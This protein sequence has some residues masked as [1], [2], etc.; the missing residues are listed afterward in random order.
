M[1]RISLW[2]IYRF[3]YALAFRSFDVQ[4]IRGVVRL[5]LEPCTYWRNIEVPAVLTRLGVKPGEKVLDL[6]SPKLASLLLSSRVGAEVWATDL[7]AYFTEEYAH[8]LKKLRDAGQ[9]PGYHIELQD[10][11]KLQYP[12]EFFDKVYSISVLEHIEGDGDSAAMREIARVLKPGGL[13]CLTVPATR[14]YSEETTLRHLYYKKHATG[15]PV[16]YQRQYDEAALRNRLVNP[17]G[18]RLSSVALYGERWVPYE[19][20][21]SKLPRFIKLPVSALGPLFS[22]LFLYEIDEGWEGEPKAAL[23]VLE[24]R[25]ASQECG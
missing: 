25:S 16:F 11:R 4:H 6:G 22:L 8:Y 23:V 17:S 13:C 14:T 5:L 9:N 7:F 19:R 24:K 15:E 3:A 1:E 18:M 21:Y 12:N 20:L 2:D 10:G